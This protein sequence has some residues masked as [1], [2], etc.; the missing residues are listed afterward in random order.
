MP[1]EFE[2][3]I[4]NDPVDFWTTVSGD[5]SGN[6]PITAQRG[7][8]YIHVIGRLKPDVTQQ[9]AQAEMDTISK[10]LEQ[11]YPDTNTRKGVGLE[12][13]L[14]A[15]VGD[16][17]PALLILLGAVGCVLLIACANVANLLLAR[18]M[19]RHKEMAIRSALGASRMRVV[20]QL[21]TESMLLSLAGG[22][23]GLVLAVWWSDVLVALGKEDI[24]RAMQ[25]GLD[26]RVLGFT[27]GVSLLTRSD[28]WFSSRAS[29]CKDS[30]D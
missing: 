18:A 12:P 20:R 15:I 8:H 28:F 16:V 26:W 27:F 25:I 30:I 4:Q 29:L 3:P 22:A 21:L 9:Q 7:A 5:T 10:R 19:S 23:L 24:P 13:A 6:S 14:L 1:S 11:Q 17:R 2:F